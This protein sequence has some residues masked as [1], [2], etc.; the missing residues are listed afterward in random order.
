MKTPTAEVTPRYII[1]SGSYGRYDGL[2]KECKAKAK[3]RDKVNPAERPRI[4]G[5]LDFI[6]QGEAFSAIEGEIIRVLSAAS[7]RR[8]TNKEL[9]YK[10]YGPT[11][12]DT[13]HSMR[14]RIYVLRTDGRLAR[15]GY[16]IIGDGREG[17]KLVNIGT[18]TFTPPLENEEE[19]EN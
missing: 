4:S 12:Y 1:A 15:A 17:Y 2:C 14:Q 7:G 16:Q 6:F 3:E 9:A 5:S 19:E 10:V 11:I 13:R 18:D 8:M